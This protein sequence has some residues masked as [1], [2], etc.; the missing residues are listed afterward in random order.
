MD[1]QI[2]QDIEVLALLLAISLGPTSHDAIMDY[3]QSLPKIGP[4]REIIRQWARTHD[5]SFV[6]SLLEEALV[7]PSIKIHPSLRA[8]AERIVDRKID[9]RYQGD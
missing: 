4:F 8:L 1:D 3:L 5:D 9:F 6:N 2:K 7:N